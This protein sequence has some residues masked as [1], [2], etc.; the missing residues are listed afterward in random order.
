[1]SV[2]IK[3]CMGRFGN[4]LF[5]YFTARI[6]S[7]NLKFKLYGPTEADREF[8]LRGIDL[9]Y[10]QPGYA[11]H[12]APVQHLGNHSLSDDFCHPDFEIAEVINDNTPRKIILDGY[13]QRKKFYIPFRDNIKK[14]FNATPYLTNN[15]D[16]A[17]HIRLGDLLCPNLRKHLLPTEYYEEAIRLCLPGKITICTDYPE[18]ESI[19]YM[20]KKYN[21]SIFNDTEKNT[22]SFLSAHNNLILSQGSF[23]FWSGFLCDGN[24]IINAIPKTGWNSTVDDIGVDLLLSEENYKYIKL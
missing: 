4:Q 15:T 18:H 12:D 21:A 17:I 22:I 8:M 9:N 3:K 20:L 24:N 10:D 23:S 5:P 16:I 19:Q 2:T 11:H 6:I 1:M 7:E 14:W 13:F